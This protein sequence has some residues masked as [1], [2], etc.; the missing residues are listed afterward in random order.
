[1]TH[2]PKRRIL[3]I[4]DQESIHQ[5][6]RKIIAPPPAEHGGLSAVEAELFGGVEPSTEL[7]CD[8][9]EIDSAFQGEE[10]V[11]L[12][13]QSLVDGRPY[14]VAFVDIRMPPGCDGIQTTRQLWEVDPDLLVVICSAYSD[15]CWED[16]VRELGRTD[17]FLILRKPFETMEVRQCAAA[18]CE[19]WMIAQQS[20]LAQSQKL[21]SIGQLAAGI[22]HE[23]NTPI[24]FIG[25]NTRFLKESFG[26]LRELLTACESVLASAEQGPLDSALVGEARAVAEA[27]DLNYLCQEVPKCID[28]S[29]EGIER[30]AKIV[31]A[32]KDFSH[33][34]SNTKTPTNLNQAIE[35]TLTVARNEWKYVA[36]L[37]LNLDPDLPLVSCLTGAFNQVILNLV[38]NAAH[39]IADVGGEN[40]TSKGKISISTQRD[41]DQ[42]V[43]RVGDTGG[44]I[45][46]AIRSKIFD[47]FF[48]TKGVGK[49]TGQGLAIAYTVVVKKHGGTISFE[50]EVGRGTTFIIRLP[51]DGHVPPVR[52]SAPQTVSSAR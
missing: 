8:T 41:N 32:M 38:V 45:P 33:P 25:D 11:T 48:T 15:Y 46:L 4:D 22:A 13:Q 20:K 23:I 24:Q 40:P 21:E 51:I 7:E 29:L 6:Y 18:L 9:Y 26:G 52:T 35:S 16:I 27:V 36:D 37:E 5:D 28:Q 49:G 34:D 12:V 47:P 19:R 1:M 10:A 39:A 50:S 14:A 31:R 30:V 17:R 43:I 44:G 3:I 42:V 2:S